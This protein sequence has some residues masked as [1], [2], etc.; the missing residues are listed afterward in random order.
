MKTDVSID[1]IP[2]HEAPKLHWPLLNGLLP[3][4]LRTTVAMGQMNSLLDAVDELDGCLDADSRIRRSIDLC[5]ERLGLERAAIFLFADGAHDLC[6]TWGT[7]LEG[8]TQDESYIR[9]PAGYHHRKATIQALGGVAHWLHFSNVPLFEQHRGEPYLCGSGWNVVTPI[10]GN[11]GPLG[12]LVNDAAASRAP[13]D[14]AR[15]MRVALF[16]RF[17]GARI[18]RTA[19]DRSSALPHPLF[20]HRTRAGHSDQRSIVV[21]MVQA[22]DADPSLTGRQLGKRFATSPSVLMRAFFVEMGIS[23]VDYRNRVRLERFLHSIGSGDGHL[24]QLALE[25]GFGSYAQFH[26]VFFKLLGTTPRQ[27]FERSTASGSLN[28]SSH[29]SLSQVTMA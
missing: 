27:F 13:I 28:P 9:F 21:S 22:L 16:C 12:F 23:L 3:R 18:E 7:N 5:R 17:L 24:M 25:S 29:S 11:R 20:P 19:S 6:G 1:L 4:P 10:L 26:R 15:Q 2:L 8:G 14:A